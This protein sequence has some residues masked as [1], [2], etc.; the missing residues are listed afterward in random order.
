MTEFLSAY[1]VALVTGLVP[2]IGLVV[3]VKLIHS[4]GQW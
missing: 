1:G 2:V 4:L 3:V